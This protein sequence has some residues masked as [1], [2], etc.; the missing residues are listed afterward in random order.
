MPCA[1]LASRAPRR[2]RGSSVIERPSLEEVEDFLQA[3]Y[4]QAVDFWMEEGDLFDDEP[5]TEEQPEPE[6]EDPGWRQWDFL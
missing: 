3:I 2:V 5:D 1:P 4:E 6:A